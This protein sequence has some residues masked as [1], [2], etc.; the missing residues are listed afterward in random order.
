MPLKT[1]D[2]CQLLLTVQ[3]AFNENGVSFYVLR[4]CPI[5]DAFV[6]LRLVN[7][8]HSFVIGSFQFKKKEIS[9]IS[10]LQTIQAELG[11]ISQFRTTMSILP[12]TVHN[13]ITVSKNQLLFF[14]TIN[15]SQFLL[16]ISMLHISSIGENRFIDFTSY[17]KVK[18]SLWVVIYMTS[19][20][21]FTT[22]W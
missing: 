12:G 1:L 7:W 6:W 16:E 17:K 2:Y 20:W 5:S 10:I 11:N 13:I 21:L 14:V 9:W 18:K 4:C 19:T 15:K 3:D 8:M 22:L